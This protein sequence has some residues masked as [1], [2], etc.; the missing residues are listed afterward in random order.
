MCGGDT[1]G[2][3]GIEYKEEYLG[4]ATCIVLD[5]TAHRGCTVKI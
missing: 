3:G 5:L 1:A 4:W 2:G